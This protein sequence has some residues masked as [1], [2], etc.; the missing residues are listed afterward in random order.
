[1][2]DNNNSSSSHQFSMKIKGLFD[3]CAKE[4]KKTKDI[5]L[6]MLNAGQLNSDLNS[7]YQELGRE[8]YQ[9]ILDGKNP[10]ELTTHSS[11][12]VT[13]IK[14]TQGKLQDCEDAVG[15]IKSSSET[16]G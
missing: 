2:A 11:D 6:K 8:V 15:D 9:S 13:R 12:L 10:E 1:M 4:L 14:E 16:A 3:S 5:G 7:Y